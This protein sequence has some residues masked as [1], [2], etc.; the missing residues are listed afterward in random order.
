[1]R[2]F[3]SF[4]LL[5]CTTMPLMADYFVAGNGAVGNPWCDGKSWVVNGSAMTNTDGVW[6]ITFEAVPAGN[7]QFKVTNGS[8]TWIGFDTFNADCS[9]LY[10]TGN[11]DAN[12]CFNLQEQQDVTITYNSTAIC[13]TGTIGN[14]YPDPT[15][16]AK[17]GVPSEYEGVMLQA[18]Y[19]NSYTLKTFDQTKYSYLIDHADEI[20]DSFDLVWLPPSG[21]GGGVG[22]YTKCYSNLTSAWGGKTNLKNLIAALAEKDCKVLAD[23]VINHCQSSAGWAQS[24]TKNNFGGYGSYTITSEHIC[25]TDE[26]FTDSG[27][28]SKSLPHGNAD[29]GTNDAGCRDLDHT[30]DYVQDMCKAY[31]LWMRDSIGFAGYRFDM[32]KGYAGTYLSEYNLAAEPFFSVSE[33]WDGLSAIASHLQEANYN[34]LAFDFALKYKFNAWKGGSS[35]SNLKNQGLRSLGLSRFAVTFIDNHDTFHRSDNQA[36]EFC[37]YNTDIS[38]KPS[39]ILQANAY[40]LSMPGVP[41]VFWPHW[42]TYKDQIADMIAVRKLAGIHSESEVISEVAQSNNYEATIVGHHHNLIL[43]MGNNR[44]KTIPE[45]YGCVY[46]GPGF[47]MYVQGVPSTYQAVD[48]AIVTPRT[49]KIIE[50]GKIYILKNNHKYTITGEKAE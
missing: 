25:S 10:A 8:N 13:L 18:F 1:M 22:Y 48:D 33:Y 6:S 26:A 5:V 37:G 45:G 47:E 43:R 19:W 2:R 39:A 38:Q 36:D 50:N 35:Y 4:L 20:G 34:T 15:Q 29:T 3:Y 11:G 24:F 46:G 49:N 28:D 12:I 44:D 17:V 41:C 23:I 31:L 16:Y 42:Y 14:N 32:T 40:L 21:N 7:Y 27:S 9:N 30:S